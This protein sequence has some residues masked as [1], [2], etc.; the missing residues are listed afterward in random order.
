M[1]ALSVYVMINIKY[2][3]QNAM[4]RGFKEFAFILSR[5]IRNIE[6]LYEK[7]SA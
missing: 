3:L 5:I 2:L 1:R 6:T 7:I 4:R